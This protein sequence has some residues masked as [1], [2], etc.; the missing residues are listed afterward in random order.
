MT[1]LDRTPVPGH[2]PDVVRRRTADVTDEEA[3]ADAVRGCGALNIAA[4][5]A[6]VSGPM[7]KGPADISHA[8][9]VRMLAVRANRVWLMRS[10]R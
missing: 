4:G 1:V 5:C 7:G 6:G 2:L 9:S 3:V 8:G 10:C